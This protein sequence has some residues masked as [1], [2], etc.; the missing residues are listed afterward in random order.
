MPK[1]ASCRLQIPANWPFIMHVPKKCSRVCFTPHNR[2][3][4]CVL[5]NMNRA[6]PRRILRKVIC[7]PICEARFE[8]ESLIHAPVPCCINILAVSTAPRRA[9]LQNRTQIRQ[10][11]GKLRGS[12]AD[13]T[14]QL[15]LWMLPIDLLVQR[16]F[17]ITVSVIAR[18]VLEEVPY[19]TCRILACSRNQRSSAISN[20]VDICSL[21]N[22][23]VDLSCVTLFSSFMNCFGG[24]RPH[25]VQHKWLGAA[26]LETRCGGCFKQLAS[27][28]LWKTTLYDPAQ[29]NAETNVM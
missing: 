12:D 2:C 1:R 3:L 28:A 22:R 6:L 9:A 17:M 26:F 27:K 13:R 18:S 8:Q 29:C 15:S 23:Q 7:K 21:P 19:C 14:T 16:S 11:S 25:F 20:F 4:F 5:G 24:R 10:A